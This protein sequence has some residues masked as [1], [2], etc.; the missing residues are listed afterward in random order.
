MN[1]LEMEMEAESPVSRRACS[2]STQGF[3]QIHQHHLQ[4]QNLQT[5]MEDD[6]ALRTEPSSQSPAKEKVHFLS[7][8]H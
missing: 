3:D 8:S 1:K 4:L 7:L 2:S 6:D 5:E